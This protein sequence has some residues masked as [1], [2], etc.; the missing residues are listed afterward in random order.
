[1]GHPND[2]DVVRHMAACKHPALFVAE[3]C[4]QTYAAMKQ[5][6][7]DLADEV[8]RNLGNSR[9]AFLGMVAYV[10]RTCPTYEARV[11]V[12][13]VLTR[14]NMPNPMRRELMH[15]VSELPISEDAG[16]AVGCAPLPNESLR[17]GVRRMINLLK[18]MDI[19]TETYAQ[20]IGVAQNTLYQWASGN[21][22][23]YAKRAVRVYRAAAEL[24]NE[25][26][27]K[28]A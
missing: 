20:R 7:G 23:P 26:V 19:G 13:A 17:D 1:M 10:A 21:R 9:N 27:T 2:A 5:V 12:C 11:A 14:K 25:K 6:S 4:V 15:A 18:R 24:A 16:L 28:N 8:M 3:A 22:K